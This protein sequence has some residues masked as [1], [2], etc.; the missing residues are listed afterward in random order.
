MARVLLTPNALLE[1]CSAAPTVTKQRLAKESALDIRMSA[2][3]NAIARVS[4]AT[5]QTT[6]LSHRWNTALDQLVA[7]VQR[8]SAQAPLPVDDAVIRVWETIRHHVFGATGETATFDPL[9]QDMRLV[10]ATA[11]VHRLHWIEPAE[12]Y[13]NGLRVMGLQ[14]ESLWSSIATVSSPYTARIPEG[15]PKDAGAPFRILALSGGG[16]RGLFTARVLELLE[17][18]LKKD[19]GGGLAEHFHFVAGTS[20]GALLACGLVAGVSAATLRACVQDRGKAVFPKRVLRLARQ[21]LGELYGDNPLRAAIAAALGLRAKESLDTLE[22]PLLV[23]AV[24]W[25]SGSAVLYRSR[26]L[27][28]AQASRVSLQDVCLASSAAPTY[29]P[30]HQLNGDRLIDGGLVANAPDF[31]ALT[32]ALVLLRKPITDV[33]LLSI[34]TASLGAGGM[35]G[36]VPR[37]G[38]GWMAGGRIVSLAISAQER[39]AAEACRRI[40]QERFV[41]IDQ[42]AGGNC[43]ELSDMDIVDASMTDTLIALADHA[44]RVGMEEGLRL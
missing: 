13:H 27:A 3:A 6:A 8:D 20:I 39:C 42:R 26:G 19:G 33:H 34:G 1:L 15:Q 11:I 12:A 32:D 44:F 7:E 35:S 17:A 24:S 41:R 30:P 36:D 23:P 40:L 5:T 43:K 14:V 9:G 29:F 28:G 25:T 4:I 16:Y 10:I 31:L 22:K 21:L 18:H 38:L 2:I 37:S